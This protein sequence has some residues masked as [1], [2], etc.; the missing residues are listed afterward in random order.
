MNPLI[1]LILENGN[2]Y[3]KLSTIQ[4]YQQIN[5]EDARLRKDN[6]SDGECIST[7]I[8]FMIGTSSILVRGLQAKN[9]AWI[10]IL[11][12]FLMALCMLFIYIRILSIY[13]GKDLFDIIEIV[14]GNVVGKV[15]CILFLVYIMITNSLVL[16]DTGEFIKTVA[17][18]E[19]PL[20]IPMIIISF[21]STWVV[22]EGVHVLGKWSKFFIVPIILISLI[23]M[24]LLTPQMDVNNILP[25]NYNGIKPIIDGATSTFSFPFAEIIAFTIV[26]P[27]FKSRETKYKVYIIGLILGTF[28]VFA[29]SLT[30]ILVLGEQMASSTYY[31]SYL[32]ISVLSIRE[33]LQRLEVIA[34]LTFIL[35]GFVKLSIYLI[36][37]YKG[38]NKLFGLN[39]NVAL[40][41]PIMLLII[42]LAYSIFENTMSFVKWDAEIFKYFAFGFQV[43]LPVL[44]LVVAIIKPKYRTILK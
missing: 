24:L 31:P 4:Y 9:D 43:I 40:V 25:I 8:L 28:G 32:T 42:N 12:A 10:A 1:K 18:A 19:T 27:N 2:T 36:A 16:R 20:I 37:A 35:G 14:F 26:L 38:F 41:T 44:I 17:F 11:L 22:K 21:L 6:I 3:I 23:G 39:N 34:T 30:N 15:I 33:L 5:M 13:P 29:N 7:I